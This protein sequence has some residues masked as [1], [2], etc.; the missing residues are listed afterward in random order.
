MKKERNAKL[1]E[2]FRAGKTMQELADYYGVTRSRVHQILKKNGMNRLSG[3]ARVKVI[4]RSSMDD[5]LFEARYIKKYGLCFERFNSLKK[6]GLLKAYVEQKSKAKLRGVRWN[7]TFV[8]WWQVWE[9][10]G[11]LS[12]RGKRGDNYVMARWM[13]KGSYEVGNVRIVTVRENSSE[14]HTTQAE[15]MPRS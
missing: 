12:E 13:D 4:G 15:S 5:A 11:K 1:V 8:E 3:G 14:V 10:S 2:L 6:A 9:G 7:L